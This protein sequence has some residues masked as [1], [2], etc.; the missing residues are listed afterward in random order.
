MSLT[1]VPLLSCVALRGSTGGVI[2]E[3]S[4]PLGSVRLRT[5]VECVSVE[6][7]RADIAAAQQFLNGAD[8]VSVFEKMRGL[9]QGRKRDWARFP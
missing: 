9:R 2:T 8:V 6:H 4:G 3:T 1:A 5:T 7:R